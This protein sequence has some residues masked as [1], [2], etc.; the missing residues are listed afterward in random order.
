M[1][2]FGDSI[3][4]P[5]HGRVID[6]V[7]SGRSPIPFR[8]L[9]IGEMQRDVPTEFEVFG[10]YYPL[11]DQVYE[12][13][14]TV[15]P[16]PGRVLGIRQKILEA[17]ISPESLERNRPNIN[18]VRQALGA[19]ALRELG[20]GRE[21]LDALGLPVLMMAFGKRVTDAADVSLLFVPSHT[22]PEPLL[23]EFQGRVQELI[24]SER[25]P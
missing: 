15:G 3:P 14:S 10:L 16:I 6:A 21:F 8:N 19:S 24:D 18:V 20:D 22:E 12:L 13:A 5:E 17:Q 7:L 23:G 1:R 4:T 11:R 9:S 2:S 25:I